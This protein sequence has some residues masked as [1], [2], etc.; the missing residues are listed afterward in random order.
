MYI[1]SES[2]LI[3]PMKDMGG[4]INMVTLEITINGELQTSFRSFE[5]YQSTESHHSFTLKIDRGEEFITGRHVDFYMQDYI[6]KKLSV[7][8]LFK[9]MPLAGRPEQYFS[10]LITSVSYE[11]TDAQHGVIILEGYSPTIL[12]DQ[13][14]NSRI[15]L[16]MNT[17]SIADYVCKDCLALTRTKIEL[18]I[19]HQYGVPSVMQYE[20]TPYNFLKRLAS[21]YGEAF[22]YSGTTLHFGMPR[23]IP[24]PV[25]LVV[26]RDTHQVKMTGNARYFRQEFYDYNER[27]NVHERSTGETDAMDIDVPVTVAA[28]AS[29]EMFTARSLHRS[30][31]KADT[32]RTMDMALRGKTNTAAAQMFII[33][34]K[35][36]IPLLRPGSIISL[37]VHE[38]SKIEEDFETGQ[39]TKFIITEARHSL[40]NIGEY[41]CCF[42]G[43]PSKSPNL[44]VGN[45]KMPCA[46]P[47]Q[48]T[49]V[50]NDD[51]LQLG[52]VKV[53][54][55]WGEWSNDATTDWIRVQS[56]DAGNSNNV[57]KNRGFV[58]IPEP[59]DQ[60]MVSFEGGHPDR[61]Y[62]SGSMFH[63]ENG[64]GGGTDND[65]KSIT[66]KS[67][68]TVELNDTA[69][70]THII[71]KDP[72]GNE[73]KFDTIGEKIVVTAPEEIIFNSKNITFNVLNKLQMNVG[74]EVLMNI[75]QKLLIETSFMEE[76]VSNYLHVQSGKTLLH[77]LNELSIQADDFTA[78]GQRKLL[79]HSEEHLQANSK[80]TLQ[81][82]G[83]D[84]N[85]MFDSADEL[86]PVTPQ[87]TAKCI[88]HFR[89]KDD[90]SG[91]FG[92]DWMRITDTH[93]GGDTHKYEDI[94]GKY[95]AVYASQPGAVFTKDAAKFSSL[96]NL[97]YE[98]H[99][100]PST[101]GGA[102][103]TYYTPWLSLFP[104]KKTV[105]KK[106]GGKTITQKIDTNY[107][108]TEVTLKVL[109]KIKEEPLR[110]ELNYNKK[111]F[112]IDKDNIT[113]PIKTPG[114][115][116]LEIKITCLEGF[117]INQEIKAVTITKG[118]DN[119]E[120]KKLAG[121]L[122]VLKNNS[123]KQSKVVFINVKT[124]LGNGI[125]DG[126]N[127][128]AGSDVIQKDYL[129]KFIK[130]ALIEPK[131]EVIDFDL[132]TDTNLNT[133]Y[134]IAN[135]GTQILNKVSNTAGHVNLTS[136]L[137]TKFN[138]PANSRFLNY[139]KV[140]FF[141]ED[142]GRID[143][144]GNITFL[145]GHANGIPSKSSVMYANPLPFFVTHELMHCLGL[146]HSFDNDGKYTYQ[147]GMT[148]NIM[149][150]S[151]M[152]WNGSTIL[153]QIS[154]WR[155]QWEVLRK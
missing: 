119:I 155:W 34:G 80:G 127:I 22:F 83:V 100:I 28:K 29:Q 77:T 154:S 20:E 47:Q 110:I 79:L 144:A 128:P 63:G 13:T 45:Y 107:N 101:T 18:N 73:I 74:N 148:E 51:P 76:I 38:W 108:P 136:Y 66:S 105:Y 2:L 104:I 111:Y 124:N 112:K 78:S 135:G 37:Q 95:G 96:G 8:F 5:L 98:P 53:K 17:A 35:T 46:M 12:L 97:Y 23:N 7:V 3:D 132:T 116:Q 39:V 103:E 88:V 123:V 1:P 11:K 139:H 33:E 50:S 60:V 69:N 120:K 91:E 4:S 24:Q 125:R 40:T 25:K 142:G 30:P 138:I 26:G 151:H 41:V 27:T 86:P 21:S 84:G 143:S 150:Y 16:E 99:I 109:I 121:R 57:T 122:K 118:T 126:L 48:A 93:I 32:T 6:G 55:I 130:Q 62:V 146:Y 71:I 90:W 134:T 94:I 36:L 19:S 15:F 147:I 9:D 141:G 81:I 61:P 106:Q 153:T 87:I 70:G 129:S 89:T 65:I 152:S 56:L 64:A 113:P 140:F 92:F 82:K 49:I 43:M 72:K 68:H 114:D 133:D 67:G 145:G 10:G 117:A 75:V 85:E 102:N 59:G 42:K 58:F 137:E 54:F 31:V 149:D 52:R 115:Y 44:P 131:I 14:E